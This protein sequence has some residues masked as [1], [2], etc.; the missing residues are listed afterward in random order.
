G[1]FYFH[2]LPGLLRGAGT[3]QAEADPFL[4]RTYLVF[5][6][7]SRQSM[8]VWAA[9]F[10]LPLFAG[11]LAAPFALRRAWPPA[12]PVLGAWLAA[13]PLVML[14]KEPFLFPRPLRWAKEDEFISPL[15]ALLI[16]APA[17]GL[18]RP[19][20]R[21]TAAALAVSV[22]A[23]LQAGDFRIHASGLMP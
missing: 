22:A 16:A 23:W 15:V 8:R 2:Y 6:N 3:L 5:H 10:A 1:V 12:R 7:E 20:M 13:W 18:P 19:W 21:W 17:W 4:P 14:A 11:L 9:G